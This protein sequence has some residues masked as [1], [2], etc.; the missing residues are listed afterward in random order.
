MWQHRWALFS[1]F[2]GATASCLVKM[3]VDSSNSP[4]LQLA[5]IHICE[6][7]TESPPSSFSWLVDFDQV[8]LRGIHFVLGELMIKYHINLMTFWK[9]LRTNVIEEL[10]IRLHLFEMD[11]CQL[12]F[13]LPVRL[14]CIIAMILTNA[15]MVA[16]FLRGIQESGSVAGTSLS[17]SANFASSAVYGAFF[18]NERMN[19][20]WCIGFTCILFGVMILSNVQFGA[21]DDKKVDATKSKFNKV[22]NKNQTIT[23]T[24]NDTW[25]SST[26]TTKVKV[27]SL[28]AAFSANEASKGSIKLNAPV[29][30]FTPPCG[31]TNQN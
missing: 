28:R 5:Q 30:E 20:K 7:F 14:V 18:F 13:I 27:A 15:Y 12:F 17:T 23:T 8:L 11:Y 2:L 16:S 25:V 24:K 9:M 22:E 29:N 6:R 31:K 4:L 1:G 3:G 19:E 21:I 10:A 26:S